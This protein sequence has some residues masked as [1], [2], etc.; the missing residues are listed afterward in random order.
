MINKEYTNFKKMYDI[1]FCEKS[2]GSATGEEGGFFGGRRRKSC[3]FNG[4][5]KGVGNG[6]PDACPG[7]LWQELSEL[8]CGNAVSG[9]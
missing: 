2:F 8:A 1:F 4:F 9:I 6:L 3:Y 7:I 5:A